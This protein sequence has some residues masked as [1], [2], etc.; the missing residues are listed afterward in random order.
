MELSLEKKNILITGVS[1][2]KGI[3]AELARVM[4]QNGANVVI[5]GYAPYDKQMEYADSDGKYGDE[6]ISE[7]TEKG[8]SVRKLPPSDLRTEGEGAGVIKKAAEC[9][10]YIDGL[11]LN[12]A[13]S[14]SV[15]M[16]E[17]TEEDINSHLHTN[18]TAAMMMIQAFAKQLP[19]GKRGAV[20]LFTSGQYLGP[21]ISE[22]AYAVSKHAIICICEQT[23]A[24]LGTQNIQV[25]CVNPGPTDTGYAFGEVHKALAEKFPS[26]RWGMPE[27][28]AKLVLFLQSDASE[29]ITG[30]VIASEGGFRRDI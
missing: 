21:M 26:G 13:Y 11:I 5:H 19:K 29:W 10:G 27:D 24:A 2:S 1:R 8:Y 28:V 20:T 30:Q 6:L 4:A 18:V 12:H 17:W 15:P 23:A 3:G 7:L 14:T 16:G 9:W 22:I 25:N